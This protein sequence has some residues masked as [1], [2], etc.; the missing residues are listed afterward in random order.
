MIDE[1]SVERKQR[2]RANARI[3]VRRR[4]WRKRQANCDMGDKRQLNGRL[5]LYEI[6][7]VVTMVVKDNRRWLTS[8]EDVL[9]AQALAEESMTSLRA[10]GAVTVRFIV[11]C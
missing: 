9:V 6:V 2:R 10:Q 8:V 7:W 4:C 1:I 5:T 3:G 11:V